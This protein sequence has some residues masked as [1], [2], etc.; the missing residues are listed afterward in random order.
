MKPSFVII[1]D[2]PLYREALTSLIASEFPEHDIKVEGTL[3]NGIAT[4]H[5]ENKARKSA[6]IVILDLS[7]P[8]SSGVTAAY[9]L[10]KECPKNPIVIISA[11]DDY[12]QVT[13]CLNAGAKLFINK[14]AS[15]TSLI[16]ALKK[17]SNNDEFSA[18]WI[19]A[20]GARTADVRHG[21][22]LTERQ[23]EVL[24]L[25]CEGKS[26]RDIAEQLGVA[27]ITAK[28]HVSAI[29]RELKVVNRTQALLA[30]Q[31]LGF[32]LHQREKKGQ[33]T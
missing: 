30:A 19:S 10:T 2:H 20:E 25:I 18:Q 26:N 15:R 11:S 6:G 8:D 14:S 9:K 5:K 28:A 4:I 23:M 31:R 1:E 27:E 17:L 13:S 3:A 24:K 22:R 16:S 33:S 12:L 7:L 29:F 21:I 32:S